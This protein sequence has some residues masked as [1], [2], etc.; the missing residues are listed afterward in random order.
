MEIVGVDFSGAKSDDRTWAARGVLDRRGLTLHD[1]RPL[2]RAELAEM[3]ASL[4]GGSVAALDFPFSV[5]QA[6]ARFWQPEAATMPDL[7][8]AAA[9]MKMAQFLALRDN[10]VSR[11]GELKRRCDNR[12]PESYSCLHKANPNLVPM[13]FYGM[14]MLGPLWRAGCSVPPLPSRKAGSAVLLE[15][16]PGA[17]IKA[18][19]LP[20][21]GYKKGASAQ[22]LRQRILG[23]LED[24]SGVAIRNLAQ[25]R[26]CCLL[27]DDCLDAIVAAVVA[28]LWA[29]D[30]S[31]FWRPSIE[32]SGGRSGK[33]SWEESGGSDEVALLEG[34]L[35]APVFLRPPSS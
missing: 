32:M 27:S 17:A 30:P 3:L 35:Y 1:C 16:M 6:F 4:P 24:R 14:Q 28:C 10:F 9:K 34:W 5:P 15:A 26:E 7:W 18:L 25:F 31:V 29:T 19:G 11:C 33:Q 21:K 12:F 22:L 8:A 23:G 13:T 20:Y 2:R